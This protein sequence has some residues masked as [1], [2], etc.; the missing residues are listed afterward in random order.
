MRW[1]GKQ[2]QRPLRTKPR[3]MRG[4]AY[5]A[6]PKL[7]I[8][9]F[10]PEDELERHQ[11]VDRSLV[12][13]VAE[14]Y[15]TCE[16][17]S[18]LREPASPAC[19][20]SPAPCAGMLGTL[21]EVFP[22]PAASVA[23]CIF[24]ATYREGFRDQTKGRGAHV[25]G[26]PRAGIARGMQK[27]VQEGGGRVGV[28]TARGGR[29]NGVRRVRRNACLHGIPAGA[30]APDQDEQRDRAHQP[31]DQE[32][33]ESRRDLP[34]RQLDP[35]AGDGEAEVHSGARVGQEEVPG[36]VEAGGDGRAGGKG[37]GLEEDGAE[38]G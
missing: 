5:A 12:A 22:G 21:E 26:D 36:Y 32:E 27:E 8:G 18:W 25:E 17:L 37:G 10:F 28:G 11:R 34:G 15:T 31:R 1:R 23:R 3:R 4:H 7:R 30:P 2:P 35:H 19:G 9:S 29:E 33:D 14:M 38:D 20:S 6:H 13:A 16:S 24:T